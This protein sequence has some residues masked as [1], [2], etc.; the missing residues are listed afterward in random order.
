MRILLT[1]AAALSLALTALVTPDTGEA[2]ELGTAFRPVD[3]PALPAQFCMGSDKVQFLSRVRMNGETARANVALA[4]EKIAEIAREQAA[5]AATVDRA[6]GPV[7][8]AVSQGR[9]DRAAHLALLI[10]EFEAELEALPAS[11]AE[12]EAARFDNRERAGQLAALE[13]KARAMP[14]ASCSAAG[15]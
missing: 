11:A 5:Y 7:Q 6:R 9:M 4:D 13:T 2:R 8:R 3:V 14:V 1:S 12:L 15:S 10:G